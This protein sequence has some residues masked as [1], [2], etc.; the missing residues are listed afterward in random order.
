M[1]F[2]VGRSSVDTISLKQHVRSTDLYYIYPFPAHM[3]VYVR[4]FVYVCVFQTQMRKEDFI[5]ICV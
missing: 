1:Q 5:R 4:E 3:F 2:A